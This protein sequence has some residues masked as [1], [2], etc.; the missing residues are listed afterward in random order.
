[1]IPLFTPSPRIDLHNCVMLM[2]EYASTGLWDSRGRNISVTAIIDLISPELVDDIFSWAA[3]YEKLEENGYDYEF[4][5]THLK[6]HASRGR[7]LAG[8]LQ[9]E[10]PDWSI[11][12]FD[13]NL[14]EYEYINDPVYN[15]DAWQ[16][17]ITA[18]NYNPPMVSN[19]PQIETMFDWLDDNEIEYRYR[20]WCSS[21]W[22]K[23]EMDATMFTLRWA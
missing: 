7:S 11:A 20:W 5:T 6:S 18:D 3:E 21:F 17:K 14:M 4:S 16:F 13:D 10:M 9:A 2:A 12:Y 23:N 22:F 19:D 8:R 15:P 1:M